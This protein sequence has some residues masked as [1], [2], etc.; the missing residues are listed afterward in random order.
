MTQ[1]IK[2]MPTLTGNFIDYLEQYEKASG[3]DMAFMYLLEQDAFQPLKI[4]V[5]PVGYPE[6]DIKSYNGFMEWLIFRFP[7]LKNCDEVLVWCGY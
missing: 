1:T 7:E 2:M 6:Q 5:D 3:Y 4:G